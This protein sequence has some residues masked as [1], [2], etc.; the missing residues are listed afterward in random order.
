[1]KKMSTWAKVGIGI[2]TALLSIGVIAA[3]VSLGNKGLKNSLDETKEKWDKF[4]DAMSGDKDKAS[5]EVATAH[6]T[7]VIEYY[8]E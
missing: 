2:G 8:V 7:Y 3:G 6:G 5:D 1:M 4:K